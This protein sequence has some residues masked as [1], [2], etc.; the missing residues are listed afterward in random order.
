MANK[1]KKVAVFAVAAVLGA[2]V[3][4]AA[5]CAD[6][7]NG[8]VPDANLKQGT[9]RTYTVVLPSNW[10]ELTYEDNNDT[11]I[12]YNIVSSFFEYDY[13]FENDQKY[14]ADG[15]INA[16]GIVDGAFTVHY[17]A[18]TALE[19]V[20]SEVDA[21]WGY[22]ADQKSTGGY[23]WKIT[24]RED[25]KWDDGT[26]IDASDFVYSMQQQ[27]DPLFKNM[28]ASTYYNNIMIK[29]AK[30]YVY[31]EDEYVYV[32][33]AS[34]G[35]AT[36]QAAI[37]AGET[38]GLAMWDFYN[39]RGAEGVKSYN[40]ETDEFE[41]DTSRT[42][43]EW[44]DITDTQLWLDP[45]YYDDMATYEA[46]YEAWQD[47]V[48]AGEATDEDEPVKPLAGDYIVSAASIYSGNYVYLEVGAPYASY[49]G[50]R[51]V[52]EDADFSW[53]N[54]GLYAESQYELV[55]CLDAP[56]QCVDADGN[57]T[58]QAAYYLQSLPLV[59]EDLY[60]QCKQ[61]PSTGSTL[62][63]TNYN[64]SKETTASWGPYTL[65]AFQ[66]GKSYTL[67]RNE[68]WYGYA[69]EDNANQ[70]NI[71]KVECEVLADVNTQWMEF[72]SGGIDEVGLDVTHKDKYRN[73]KYTIYSPGTGTFGINIYANLV[74]LKNNGRNNGILAI[75]EFRKALSLA[76]DRDDYNNTIY[77]SHQTCYG[78]MG[79]SYY[80]DVENATTLEDG[81]IY[82][83]TQYAK[84]AL[85]RTYGFT[86]NEDGTW[87]ID[88]ETYEADTDLGLTATDVAYEALTGYDLTQAKQL[89]EEAYR[90]LTE[91]AEEYGYDPE[92]KI[93]IKYG[94]SED[95]ENTQRSYRY[96]KEYIENLVEGTSLEGKI[97]VTFD[98]SFSTKWADAFKNGEYDLAA[99]TGFSGGALDPAGF[100]QCYVD[101][102]AGL[103]YSTW[104]DTEAEMLTYT[105]PEGDYDGA[106]ETLT[107][108]VFN[109][110]CCLNGIAGAYEQDYTYNW[111]MGFIPESA[112]LQ[113]LAKLEEVV[114]SKYYT[115]ITTSEYSATVFGAKFS[116]LS[117]EYNMFMGFGGYR[118]MIVNYTDEEWE[119]FVASNNNNL[120]NLYTQ[121]V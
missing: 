104:W 9:Y 19:D 55:I 69:L 58:Y 63:T 86:Q 92:K 90:I 28:R 99:G 7:D 34:K 81:G 110:Y 22:T 82:R 88:G 43:P 111:G 61:Q 77:T 26:P 49:V 37:D 54:V 108:S 23:A 20:T 93:E 103:M 52:N 16:D 85:L 98:A 118:Y 94:T 31:S 15:T 100:L 78:I 73:S 6:P 35:Y 17:S 47:A 121:S 25:L 32:S 44:V 105:M 53:D 117:E 27:L 40:P 84:E 33:V 30:K 76:L 5:A 70:Y 64:T 38:V 1:L 60:E 96:I 2:T 67:E 107:M 113:L 72:L 112:R 95:N 68:N 120:E 10:N 42:C 101:P 109:W 119:D 46:D 97:N 80:Y 45:V 3:V 79:P 62:W 36:N 18:A 29:G 71:T 8:G 41:L 83:N 12:M 87:T 11:Q 114:L 74:G 59:K 91:N 14:N 56:I 50:V 102:N 13:K 4:G 39:L 66:G 51:T 89:V 106:G 75:T 21:K 24:L 115:I 48:E 116:N 65:T 57:L